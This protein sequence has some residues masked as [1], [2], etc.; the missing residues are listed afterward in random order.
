MWVCRICHYINSSICCRILR[1]APY[2]TEE[3]SL[4]RLM[5]PDV[6]TPGQYYESVFSGFL[7]TL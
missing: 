1:R 2:D 5:I 7:E 6:L 3:S 4:A